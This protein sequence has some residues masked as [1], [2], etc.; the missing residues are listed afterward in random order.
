MVSMAKRVAGF[1]TTIFS[2]MNQLAIKHHAVNLGQGAPNFEGPSEI[3]DAAQRALFSGKN[4]QYAPGY[5]IKSLRHA[6]AEHEQQHFGYNIDP[7][8]QIT[9][10]V[11]ATEAI[12]ASILGLTDPGDEVILFE[13]FYDSYVP[14]L[15]MAGVTPRYLPLRP[16][17]WSFDVDELLTLFNDKT[18]AIIINTPHNPTGKIF[19]D[20]ELKQIAELCIQHDVIAITDE[21]YEHI[22]FDGVVHRPLITFDGMQD[23]TVKISSLGKTFSTTGWKIGW[24]VGNQALITGVQR[25]RQYMSFCAAHPLQVGA[26]AAL[27]LPASYYVE[28]RDMYQAKRDLLVDILSRAG[29]KP[30]VPQGSYFV[31]ADFS[32]VFDGDDIA[33]AKWLTTD[34]GVACIPPTVFYTSKHKHF[35]EKQA[36]FGFCKTDDILHQAAEKLEKLASKL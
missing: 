24:A 21:V 27:Q 34:I 31:M 22:V 6:I 9:V 16:P 18:R 32:D 14:N 19:S 29:L 13:P 10:T 36:R 8:R 26:V 5:G 30:E 25:A 12:F 15:T 3:L 2:E 23:R 7:D 35:V 28:L 1:G 33:F 4:N 11:G 17:E 20:A